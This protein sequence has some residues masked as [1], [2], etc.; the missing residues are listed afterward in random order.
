MKH[1]GIGLT[2]ATALAASVQAGIVSG[3]DVSVYAASSPVTM[4]SSM[5]T[6]AQNATYALRNGLSDA[7]GDITQTPTAYERAA[8]SMSVYDMAYSQSFHLWRGVV[9]PTGAF[10]NE[11]GN[12]IT[13]GLAAVATGD[14]QLSLNQIRGDIYAAGTPA[15]NGLHYVISFQNSS[16]G[17]GTALG[18]LVGADGL[19]N[20]P[21]DIL[22][23]SGSGT[24]LV[25]AIYSWGGIGI[26]W[27]V[28]APSQLP[29]LVSQTGA[30]F[31]C[32]WRV[33]HPLG[34]FVGTD[35]VVLTPAPGALPL[36][37]F[38]LLARRR[39]S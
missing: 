35:S 9:S 5:V 24:Q 19:L 29:G 16:Y 21:D 36:L 15:T 23:T 30:T 20:T 17:N 14:A 34:T 10:A 3:V 37:C 1:L 4:S 32:D 6:W 2:A 11:W 12:A 26:G 25:D 39:R 18:V 8:D 38:A 7:G 33:T 22:V 31:W 27:S 28:H 13:F